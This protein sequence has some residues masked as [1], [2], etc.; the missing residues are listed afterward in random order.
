MRRLLLTTA[1]VA[2]L[3]MPAAAQDEDIVAT[4]MGAEQFS[5]LVEL[6]SAAGLVETLQ[7][8]G[9]FTVFA[10][11]NDAFTA[12]TKGAIDTLTAP[13]N[14]EALVQILTYHVVPGAVLSGDLEDGMSVET[15]EGSAVTIGVG[16]G[17]TVNDATVVTPDIAAS[18]GVIHAIDMVLMPP[19]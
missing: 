1:G 6:V 15:I 9:P 10:P 4:A 3:A 13:E 17:V 5:T 19:E 18:N 16:D 12:L 8:E 11:T 2:A 7:G 14:R